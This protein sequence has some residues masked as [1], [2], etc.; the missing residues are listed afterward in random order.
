M[1]VYAHI[2]MHVGI[3]T[4]VRACGCMHTSVHVGICIRLCMWVYACMSVYV[5][6]CMH[7]RACGCMHA[8][9]CM[10]VYACM[11]VYMWVYACMSVHVGASGRDICKYTLIVDFILQTSSYLSSECSFVSH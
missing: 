2:S 11:S 10:W 1:S 4:H 9:P 5:G 7:V 6:I 3:C 8:C